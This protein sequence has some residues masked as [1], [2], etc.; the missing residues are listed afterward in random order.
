MGLATIGGAGGGGDPIAFPDQPFVVWVSTEGDD[1][2]G[3]IGN[4]MLPFATAGYAMLFD[5]I[6]APTNGAVPRLRFPLAADP[7]AVSLDF[8]KGIRFKKGC[9]ARISSTKGTLTT[10][11]NGAWFYA[12]LSS[13]PKL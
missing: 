10:S 13:L 11:S 3:Q 8:P 5:A 1:D 9:W 7:A 12:V 4:P 6:E 2:T